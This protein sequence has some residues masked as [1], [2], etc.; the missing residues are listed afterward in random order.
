MHKSID[1][2][3]DWRSSEIRARSDWVHHLQA[4]EIAE[5]EAALAA[6]KRQGIGIESVSPE[7]FPLR[8]FPLIVKRAHEVLENG[9]GM[10]LV[11]GLPVEKHPLEDMRLVYWALGQYLGT[12]VTQSHKG[13][14]LGD[15]QDLSIFSDGRGRAYQSSRLLA[16]HT[17]SCD[18][19]GL[20]VIRT[21][22]TGGLSKIAS[23]VAIHNELARTRPDLLETL[24]G[25]FVGYS[26]GE[27]EGACWNQPV[28]S[29]QEDHFSC[30]ASFVYFRLAPEQFPEKV[31]PLTPQQVEA[32]E[33]FQEIANRPELHFPMMFEPGDLQLLNNHVTLHART[34]FEDY[35]EIER[36]RHLLRLWLSVPNSRPLSPL[37]R[38]IFRDIRPGAYRGG[39]PSTARKVIYHSNVS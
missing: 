18:V 28:F 17:D 12:A 4:D 39:Y 9:C 37:L 31:P 27:R 1:S 38:D 14:V 29:I 35:A 19:V 7:T 24:Y 30:K 32:L 15:V 23:S 8:L 16:F 3:A 2:P 34:E 25:N 5:I 22:K 11:R 21:A 36:K 10:F 33:L 13:D 6:A 26:P 20:L